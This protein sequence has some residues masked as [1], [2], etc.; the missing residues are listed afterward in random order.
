MKYKI[1]NK[2]RNK[3]SNKERNTR[4]KISNKRSYIEDIQKGV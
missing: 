3:L 4:S 2:S 1:R